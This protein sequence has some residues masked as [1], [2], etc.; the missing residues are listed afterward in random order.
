MEVR[1]MAKKEV[2]VGFKTTLK[3]KE[4]LY[5]EAAELGFLKGGGKPNF[6]S[7]CRA[8][9]KINKKPLCREIYADLININ[10]NLLKLGANFNQ[11]NYTINRENVILNDKGL[12][13]ENNRLLLNQLGFI[14]SQLNDLQTGLN[15]MKKI[16]QEIVNIEGA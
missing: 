3:D 5:L 11:L 8:V 10:M 7:F 15:P 16:M 12:H 13:N 6:S 4:N 1:F 2:M 14:K 9:F